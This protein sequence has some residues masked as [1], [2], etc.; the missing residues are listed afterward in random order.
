M[1]EDIKK[2]SKESI[3]YGIGNVVIK[4]TGFILIPIYTNA[5]YLSI[6]DFGTLSI[7]DISMQIIIPILGLSLHSGLLRFYWD[8]EDTQQRKKLFSSLLFYSTIFSLVTGGILIVNSSYLSQFLFENSSYARVLS[9]VVINAIFMGVQLPINNLMR[10]ENKPKLYT[11]LSIVK[12]ISTLLFTLYFIVYEKRGIEGIFMAQIIGNILYFV[13][14]TPYILKNIVFCVK[15]IYLKK[16]LAYSLPLTF[17][18]LSL[19]LLSVID[20]FSL[21]FLSSLSNVGIYTLGYKVGGSI[22][23]LIVSSIGL[24]LSPVLF[25]AINDKNHKQLYSK[26]LTY[27]S[28]GLMWVV[29]FI[30]IFSKEIILL[31]AKNEEYLKATNIVPIIAMVVFFGMMKDI[32]MMG[33]HVKKKTK[34]ISLAIVFTG[35]LN[36]ILNIL[37]IPYLGIYGV[38]LASLFSQIT[39]FIS[40]Y[41]FAQK[42]HYIKYELRKI[43]FIIGVGVSIYGFSISFNDFSI[44]V[45]LIVKS[46]IFLSYPIWFFLFPFFEDKEKQYIKNIIT[47][48]KNKLL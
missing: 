23:L 11:S 35:V 25:K 36:L 21:N 28:L 7:L 2:I 4:V 13:V 19:V 46:V 42:V 43:F 44:L 38:A 27:Y 6:S 37:L 9:L 10:I 32:S 29:L 14:G 26:T 47:N 5:K 22:K 24:A 12:F 34:T 41:Y 18:S 45:S 39:L 15:P 3:I 20:R 48:L 31:I 8:L 1:I 30:A 17:S 40:I 16:I 33:L